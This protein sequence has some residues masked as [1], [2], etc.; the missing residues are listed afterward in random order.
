MN[1]WFSF[2]DICSTEKIEGYPT[3][4]LYSD[5]NFMADYNDDRKT[6]SFY[7]FLKTAP[8]VKEEL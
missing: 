3:I 1:C 6:D 2:S 5:G 7:N 4:K 8:V